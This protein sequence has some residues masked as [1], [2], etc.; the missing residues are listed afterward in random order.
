MCERI[1]K[2]STGVTTKITEKRLERD[3]H[4][5]RREEGHLLVRISNGDPI[6]CTSTRKEMENKD[7]SYRTKR[8]REI[9]NHSNDPKRWEKPEKKQKGEE[10][11]VAE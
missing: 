8:K 11:W 9:Q 4:V 6:K 7:V 2:S 10:S 3:G 1:S 5:K